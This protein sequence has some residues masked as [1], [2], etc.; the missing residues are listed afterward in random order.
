MLGLIISISHLFRNWKKKFSI[1]LV[2]P[3]YFS[4]LYFLSGLFI[5]PIWLPLSPPP[6][7]SPA[8][9][10]LSVEDL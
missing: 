4:F 6:V 10:G 8:L 1:F 5:P 7:P 3:H 9:H 2:K